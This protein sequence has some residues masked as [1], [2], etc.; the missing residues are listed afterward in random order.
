MADVVVDTSTVV[1]WYIPEQ[2]HEQADNGD[3][4]D[5]E[6]LFWHYPH[7]HGAGNSPSGA[8][9]SGDF[10]LI[11][12]FEGGTLELYDL[13]ADLREQRDLADA[14]PDTTEA[15]HRELRAWR[16]SVDAQMPPPNPN[17]EPAAK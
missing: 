14:M 17:Y 5:R 6:A 12:Y 3:A 1:K 7:Y 15:L 2:H 10:K 4:L 16:D 9:R 13:A 11:E 8:I